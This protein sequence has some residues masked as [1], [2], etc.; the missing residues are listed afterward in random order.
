MRVNRDQRKSNELL[1]A[2][3]NI[4]F[5]GIQKEVLHSTVMNKLQ[6][7]TSMFAELFA[8]FKRLVNTR[9]MHG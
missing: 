4:Q 7:N 5:Y 1:A 2:I 6:R 8:L 3:P 9:A